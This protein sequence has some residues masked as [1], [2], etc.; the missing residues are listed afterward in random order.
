MILKL[1]IIFKNNKVVFENYF[2][3][4]ILQVLNS[5]FYLL[6]YPYLIR[7]LGKESYG[8]YVF[9]MSI[10]NY[11][12]SLVSFGFDFPAVKEIAKNPNNKSIKS[13]VISCVFTAKIYLETLSALIFTLLILLIPVLRQYWYIYVILFGN[14]FVNI[15]FPTWFFQGIQK[16]RIV[17]YIQLIFKFLSLPFIFLFVLGPNDIEEF[18]FIV[19]FFN[20]AG[21]IAA[22]YL[23]LYNE[24]IKIHW[25][26]FGELKLWYKDALP[27][28]WSNAG[29]AIKQ[30]SI[31]IMIGTYFNMADVAL[32]DL[33][34]KIISIPNILFGSIN[35]ALFPK[36]ANDARKEVIKKIFKFEALAGLIVILLVILFGKFIILVIGG[37]KMID[38]YPIAVVLS[39]GVLTLLLVSAYISFIFVPQNKYYLVTQNQL[40]AFINFFTFSIIGLILYKNILSIAVAWTLAGLFEI[41]YC[42]I[43]IKK[44]E[45]F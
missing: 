15:L 36:I 11:F 16:M 18:S 34:Y 41:V 22:S 44:H 4:T 43:L 27:F 29:A 31:A 24:K 12:I 19:T 26:S 35:G 21:G 10:I 38:A 25:I 42:N 6:I 28:F 17:T 45:L 3:M 32:Y 1:K 14:T 2:F 40:V 7:T 20:F 5:L 9:A 13:H 37:P 8:Q 23:I 30:Q 33:A 39:F